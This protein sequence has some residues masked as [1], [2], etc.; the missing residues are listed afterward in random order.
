MAMYEYEIFSVNVEVW[1]KMYDETYRAA[2]T[3]NDLE[4]A[5]EVASDEETYVYMKHTY[6]T[7][8]EDGEY[9]VSKEELDRLI[10]KNL[11]IEGGHEAKRDAQITHVFRF[12]GKAEFEKLM[13][14]EELVNET[15]FNRY[16]SRSVGFCF[17]KWE[18]SVTDD[19]GDDRW[20]SGDQGY[21]WFDGARSADYL[22]EFEVDKSLLSGGAGLY[23]NPASKSLYDRGT[24]IYEWCTTRYSTK[25]F[26]VLGYKR[27]DKDW[28]KEE[29]VKP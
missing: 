21:L 22:V 29:W 23:K 4:E 10:Q 16:M 3:Y 20:F 2:Y 27:H 11:L 12:M 9:T 15:K 7:V 24:W 19:D 1:D 13:N 6:E 28:N 25:D 14:G 17:M 18:I 8:W 26:K 5:I